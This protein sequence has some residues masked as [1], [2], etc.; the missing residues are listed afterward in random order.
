MDEQVG[1]GMGGGSL[2]K[3][4]WPNN[5]AYSGVGT[6][7]KGGQQ[8]Q[9]ATWWCGHDKLSVAQATESMSTE[10]SGR[11]HYIF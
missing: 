1:T 3:F 7:C 6:Y 8:Q 9:N 4:M 5:K 10:Q 11:Q 2:Q